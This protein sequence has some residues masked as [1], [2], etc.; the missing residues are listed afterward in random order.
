MAHAFTESVG[1][2][3]LREENAPVECCGAW[4]VGGWG[5]A[6]AHESLPDGEGGSHVDMGSLPQTAQAASE[7]GYQVPPP[8]ECVP[9]MGRHAARI[10]ENGQIQQPVLL[11]SVDGELVGIEFMTRLYFP[12]IP[13]DRELSKRLLWSNARI[14]LDDPSTWP[15]PASAWDGPMGPHPGMPEFSWH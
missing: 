9:G 7:A 2:S 8:Q 4:Y 10:G 3:S 11:Y 6:F 12:N 14:G 5:A 15:V 1:Y 13:W